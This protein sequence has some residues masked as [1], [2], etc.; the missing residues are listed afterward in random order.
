MIFYNSAT[1][2]S[3]ITNL[4]LWVVGTGNGM[5]FTEIEEKNKTL[6]QSR[7]KFILPA[8]QIKIL[9]YGK[10]MTLVKSFGKEH[11]IQR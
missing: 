3:S 11:L 1:F 4:G 7:L 10:F 2:G 8:F 5:T 6:Q 9:F